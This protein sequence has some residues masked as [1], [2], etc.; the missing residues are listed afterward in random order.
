MIKKYQLP[1]QLTVILVESKKSPV[2]TV[3]MWVR[4]GS[5]DERKK[6]EGISH[7]I[8]HLVFKG[9]KSFGVGE[10]ASVIEASGGELNAFT[11]FDQTVFHV[12]LSREHIST[13]LQVIR[14]MMGSPNFDADEI[15]KEREVV[16]EEIKR[17]LD[18]PQRESSRLMFTNAF[19]KH[20]YGIP[21][22]GYP[23]TVRGVSRQKILSYFQSRYVPSNMTLLVAGDFDEKTLRTLIKDTYG[24]MTAFKLKKVVRKK[25]STQNKPRVATKHSDFQESYLT[26]AWKGPKPEHKDI[27]ALEVL[28][29][30]L[31]QGESSRLVQAARIKKHVANGIGSG[32]YVLKDGSLFIVSSSLSDEN[33]EELLEIIQE[34]LHRLIVSGPTPEEMSKAIV[35]F[36]S[37]EFFSLETVD[38]LARK[39]GHFD[40]LVRDPHHFKK[41]M[42]DVRKVT[43]KDVA[44]VAKKYLDPKKISTSFLGRRDPKVSEK[45]LT[46][47]VKALDKNLKSAKPKVKRARALKTSIKWSA[48]AGLSAKASK[49]NLKNGMSIL[50]RVSSDTPTVSVRIAGLGGIRAEADGRQGSL[51]LLSGTW[52]SG[53]K[54]LNEEQIQKKMEGMAAS[55]HAFGGRNSIGVNLEVLKT[56]ER[57]AGEILREVLVAPEFP[58]E[59]IEREKAALLEQL[60]ARRD[61]PGQVCIQQFY[62]TLFAGHPY[63]KDLSGEPDQVEKV[64]KSD[65][66]NLWKTC[67]VAK[68]LKIGISGDADMKYW[69]GLFED[70]GKDLESGKKFEKTFPLFDLKKPE[71]KFTQMDKEQ[72]HIVVG[73]RGLTLNDQDRFALQLVQSVLAGQGGRLFIEL[74]DK[75]SLAYTVS[76]LRMEGIDTG[77]F[78]AYIACSPEKAEKSVQMLREEFN[79]MANDLVDE[80]ELERSKN[81]IIGRHNIDLQRNS[82]I[83]SSLVFDDLYDLDFNEMYKFPEYIRAVT[84][85]DLRRVAKR[86]LSQPEV[87]SVAGKSCPDSI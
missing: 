78:G 45:I 11:S 22:I 33:L 19:K 46:Q 64:K 14:E 13:G 54:N 12:T 27:P 77:Y 42:A 87:V 48:R 25:E 67:A 71:V 83:S 23:E 43:A 70:I 82:A 65:I 61:H 24:D 49:T 15:D 68:N 37:E 57:D 60:K 18:S 30:V 80:K 28:G 55:M 32:T 73:Y 5:A 79:K 58:E 50:H 41:F 34:E 17:S 36:E 56:F 8:E 44:Q 72:T 16:C 85:Q 39:I 53:T 51:E 38:G 2:V 66:K 81:Y 74:R 9:T 10:I 6:E 1:N 7:F 3:Q 86:I 47:F 52:T 31:G 75:N 62:A 40:D 69:Q 20:P 76:P 84:P 26:F 63:E 21:V 4:T 59:I 35:N 29:L